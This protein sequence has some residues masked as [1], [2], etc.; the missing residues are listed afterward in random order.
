[1]NPTKAELNEIIDRT[2]EAMM[3]ALRE[4]INDDYADIVAGK[5]VMV[6]FAAA[7]LSGSREPF[8]IALGVLPGLDEAARAHLAGLTDPTAPMP[9][10]TQG[11]IDSARKDWEE[12]PQDGQADR[13]MA[14]IDTL[15][16]YCVRTM[17]ITGAP[18]ALIARAMP[19]IAVRAI[20]MI[21][22][23]GR[24]KAAVLASLE[25]Y[26]DACEALAKDFDEEG[27]SKPK[28]PAR[29]NSA[30]TVEELIAQLKTLRPSGNA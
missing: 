6:T 20:A 10:L 28:K 27:E 29:F 14:L 18:P 2:G 19:G 23:P 11:L 24:A 8:T 13:I 5:P 16:G 15:A 21:A 30:D 7:E 3:E 17:A 1:M 25:H 9:K 4:A 22:R 12:L 26:Q